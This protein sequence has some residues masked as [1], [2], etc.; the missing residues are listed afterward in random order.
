[1]SLSAG[2]G[3][4]RR[5][6]APQRRALGMLA[7]WSALAAVPAFASGL[8]VATALDRG[9]LTG[10]PLAGVGWLLCFAGVYLVAAFA[11]RRLYPWLAE[12]IEPLRDSL[13]T[14]VTT[15]CVQRAVTRAEA[16]DGTGVAQATEQV[17]TVRELLSDL[18]RNAQQLLTAGVAIA[19]LA[20]L[21]PVLALLVAPM[22]LLALAGFAWFLRV[23]I[24]RQRAVILAGEQVTRTATPV[25]SGARD[26]VACAAEERATT[27]VGMAVHAHAEAVRAFARARL[28]RVLVLAVG[29]QLPLL[30]VLAVA[31]WL[32]DAGYV[33][34]G[35]VGGA[36]VYLSQQLEPAM[37]FLVNAAGTWLVVLGVVLGRL[38]EVTSRTPVLSTGT[39]PLPPGQHDL[40]VEHLTFAYSPHAEPVI[41]DLCLDLPEGRHLAVVG[42]SGVGKSTLAN[43][44][45]GLVTPQHGD[46]RLGE[47]GLRELDERE[48]RRTVA[49]IPQEA[50]VFAG[51]VEDNLCYL[52]P[53]AARDELDRVA[54]L[55][56]LQE[57]V[58]QLGGYDA[59]LA[60]GG[61]GLSAGQRQLVALARVFLSPAELVILDEATCHLD[62]V[63]EARVETAFGA[64]HGTLVVIA[65][66]ISSAMRAEQILLMDGAGTTAGSHEDLLAGSTLYP[67]LVGHWCHGASSSRR[68]GAGDPVPAAR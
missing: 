29:V 33:T 13:L 58:A 18:L 66:R 50:Y 37:R 43:L 21:S 48:L 68:P 24:V 60:P 5:H 34:V 36:V 67:E 23:L 61:E 30:V 47:V 35:A 9:F 55:L 53:D 27:G 54:A 8:L 57:T 63:A 25:V 64:R 10:R 31:P 26:V 20:V 28:T 6:L 32:I 59:Q 7:A 11:T 65:H 56:G 2:V 3:L 16:P 22:L 4:L 46:V 15:A 49:L 62:P 38:S 44:L 52:R 42:P 1:M 51:T 14:A 39:R 19:G 40:R 12:T 41:R 17:D 45:G